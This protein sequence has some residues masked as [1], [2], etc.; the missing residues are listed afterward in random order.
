[1]TEVSNKVLSRM[2]KKVKTKDSVPLLLFVGQHNTKKNLDGVIRACRI[3]KNQGVKFRLVTAGDGPDFEKLVKLAKKL[4]LE[5]EVQ[6]LGFVAN[7]EEL[8][9]LYELADL[10]VFPSVYDNAP[11]VLREA[12]AAGT[13]GLL[14]AGSTAA[15]NYRDGRNA[16]IARDE[17]PEAIAEK[18]MEAM[19]RLEAVGAEAQKTIPVSW[20]KIMQKVMREYEEL[21]AEKQGHIRTIS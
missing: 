13:A 10:L 12:A 8:M 19:P 3:L 16:F 1:M 6:F 18:I 15:E 11:M 7:F 9:A 5:R 2:S 4:E 21:I 17:S 20:E 14:V